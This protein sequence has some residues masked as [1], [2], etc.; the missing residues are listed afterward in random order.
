MVE[1]SGEMISWKNSWI[2]KSESPWS[3]IQKFLFVNALNYSEFTKGLKD[4]NLQ[5]SDWNRH[6]ILV[7]EKI[8]I[9]EF[10]S[11]SGFNIL[12]HQQKFHS[13]LKINHIDEKNLYE[14]FEM[15]FRYC[16]V[17]FKTGYHSIYHQMSCYNKCIYHNIKLETKCSNCN[18]EIGFV[19]QKNL[20]NDY[21][22]TC[23][24]E[25]VKCKPL[26]EL[27][28][29]WEKHNILYTIKEPYIATG[30]IHYFLSNYNSFKN[31][32]TCNQYLIS[33]QSDKGR[34]LTNSLN[35][36][37]KQCYKAILRHFKA[38]CTCPDNKVRKCCNCRAF[39]KL[40]IEIEKES[41]DWISSKFNDFY[42]NK[43]RYFINHPELQKFIRYIEDTLLPKKLSEEALV[44]FIT[45]VFY[46]F[47]KNRFEYWLQ[48]M[49]ASDNKIYMPFL[50]SIQFKSSN[51][52]ELLIYRLSS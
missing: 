20:I 13:N 1:S 36:R 38:R 52:A 50:C 33:F 40:R 2:S 18:C 42:K 28:R 12:E 35:Y 46:S 4:T 5:I 30:K 8:F 7:D 16:P 41:I 15:R 10:H 32:Y 14:L 17:C 29:S 22:C 51:S 27:I 3:I 34:V 26:I 21:C 43:N 9:E 25:Y 49:K 31:L 39:I 6:K 23:G 47:I 37:I 24:N 19:N 11:L 48:Y 44:N 45:K